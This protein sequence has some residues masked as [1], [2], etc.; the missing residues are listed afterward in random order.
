VR[1]PVNARARAWAAAALLSALL[2]GC[3]AG[4]SSRTTAT[5]PA[6]GAGSQASALLAGIPQRGSVLGDGHAPVTVQYFADLQCPFCRRFTL[7]T[8]PLLIERYVRAG[9]LKLEYRSL[10]TATHQPGVFRNQQVAALAAGEQDRLWNFIDLFYREQREE[11]SGYVTESFLQ[12]LAQ[13]IPGLN[14]VAWTA[15]RDEP[16]LLETLARDA[17]AAQES[18]LDSTPSFRI[19]GPTGAPYYTAINRLL[20]QQ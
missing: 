19:G 3:G 6:Q 1:A 11:N 17:R 13:Q 20:G 18:G 9:K 10:E 8:L 14:L 16:R 7:S 15:A 5:A 2:A 12:G 4:T